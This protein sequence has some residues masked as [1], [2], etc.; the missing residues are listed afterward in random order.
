MLYNF[1]IGLQSGCRTMAFG[2]CTNPRPSES[3]PLS[4]T[5]TVRPKT[6]TATR[7]RLIIPFHPPAVHCHPPSLPPPPQK[8]P[9]NGLPRFAFLI[10]GKICDPAPT[11]HSVCPNPSKTP[12]YL[13]KKPGFLSESRQGMN[14]TEIQR[15]R[16]EKL[17]CQLCGG[18][19]GCQ[20][21]HTRLVTKR[22]IS[23]L[24]SLVMH[25]CICGLWCVSGK[26]AC[27]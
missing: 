4:T 20:P 17:W 7:K 21:T 11:D 6:D 14:W 9:W 18:T 23:L 1:S 19:S 2:W 15:T 24:S 12:G 27:V 26:C 25:V 22:V 5:P 8:N 16:V 10:P 3:G 13:R